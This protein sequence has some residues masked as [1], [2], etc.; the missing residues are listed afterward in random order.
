MDR[1]VQ[2]EARELRCD[3]SGRELR[4]TGMATLHLDKRIQAE[5]SPSDQ[6]RTLSLRCS[7]SSSITASYP[8]PRMYSLRL[9]H[10][11]H[12]CL[13]RTILSK[14]A[15]QSS[16]P[17]SRSPSS[18]LSPPAGKDALPAHP[19]PHTGW[20]KAAS[21]QPHMQLISGSRL[22][23]AQH[24]HLHAQSASLTPGKTRA[25]IHRPN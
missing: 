8:T 18:A 3:T 25:C 21:K 4:H 10:N 13:H 16:R 22:A 12:T 6:P 5:P 15:S 20:K 11:H 1:G 7:Q 14:Q 24:P 9:N 19:H 23:Y 2:E 17:T